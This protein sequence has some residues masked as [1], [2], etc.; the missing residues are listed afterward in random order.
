MK[1]AEGHEVHTSDTEPVKKVKLQ[2]ETQVEAES[3][4]L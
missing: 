2:H 4:S 1:Q 3:G